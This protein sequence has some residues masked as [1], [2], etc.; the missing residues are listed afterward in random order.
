RRAQ[1]GACSPRSRTK[2]RDRAARYLVRWAAAAVT[3]CS[4]CFPPPRRQQLKNTV[5]LCQGCEC[6]VVHTSRR[7]GPL[8]S[9]IATSIG[10]QEGY[11]APKPKPRPARFVFTVGMVL[12][13]ALTILTIMTWADRDLAAPSPPTEAIY[14]PQHLN[15]Y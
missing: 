1:A 9:A 14:Q 7:F 10:R 2:T 3:D 6:E 12:A 8:K 5:T 11:V 15:L 4:C 13:M